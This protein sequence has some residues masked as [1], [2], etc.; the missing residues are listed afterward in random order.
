MKKGGVGGSYYKEDNE[1]SIE[2]VRLL[3]EAMS[4]QPEPE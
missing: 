3:E 2:I 4:V 1:N